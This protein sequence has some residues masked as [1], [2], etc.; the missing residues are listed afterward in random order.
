MNTITFS[1]KAHHYWNNLINDPDVDG[2]SP[3]G[4]GGMIEIYY[5]TYFELLNFLKLYNFKSRP[6]ILE[7]G[8]GSGRWGF[9]LHPYVSHYTGIDISKISIKQAKKLSKSRRLD[10]CDFQCVSNQDFQ[11]ST[12]F[13]II[14]FGGVTQYIE[15]KALKKDLS[16]LRKMLKPD[17]ILIDRSTYT[18][19]QHRVINNQ[20]KYFAIYRTEKEL[21]SIFKQLGFKKV[22]S[23]I[24]YKFLRIGI[25]SKLFNY[26][27]ILAILRKI[28]DVVYY[29][30]ICLTSFIDYLSPKIFSEKEI[31]KF[32]HKFT[33]FK[34]I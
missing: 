10:N 24:S 12:K 14:Y 31:G 17:G 21:A 5:R 26:P 23:Q 22:S 20:I 15:D 11:S 34:L 2:V 16:H 19:E 4:G 8:C 28:P 18:L 6:N 1:Q 33:T 32:T 13:D 29:A 7:V 30:L 27:P 9:A 25:L 3:M